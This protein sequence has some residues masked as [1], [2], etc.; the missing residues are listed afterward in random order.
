[1]IVVT[2]LH[3]HFSPPHL[4]HVVSEMRRLGPPMIRAF[5]DIET[6]AWLAQE[7]THRLRAAL[8]LGIAPIMAPVRWTR[9]ANALERARFAAIQRG[10]IFNRVEVRR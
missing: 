2:P 7:G 8:R 10:H 1:M 9:G 4:E 3:E 5:L 6:G